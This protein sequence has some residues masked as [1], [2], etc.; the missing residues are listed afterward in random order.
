MF[1]RPDRNELG[2]DLVEL[3]GSVRRSKKAKNPWAI[4]QSGA[5]KRLQ[6]QQAA[7]WGPAGPT[8]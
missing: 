1:P 8:A 5:D 2:A 4:W 3:A 7:A 6:T